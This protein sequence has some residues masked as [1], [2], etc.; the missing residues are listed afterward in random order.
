MSP[1]A[2]ENSPHHQ[3]RD[4]DPDRRAGENQKETE[5]RKEKADVL[6]WAHGR[7]R[8]SSLAGTEV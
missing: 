5:R 1:H 6:L 4:P 2:S 8:T 3:L 7:S